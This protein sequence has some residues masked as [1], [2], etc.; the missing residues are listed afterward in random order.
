M[1]LEKI[2]V[3]EVFVIFEYFI[4]EPLYFVFTSK[5]LGKNNGKTSLD[6]HTIQAIP[7]HI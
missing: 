1:F 2:F 7:K 5:M 3:S 4:S 6:T